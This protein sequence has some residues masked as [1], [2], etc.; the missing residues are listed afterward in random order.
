MTAAAPLVQTL[1]RINRQKSD[2]IS[3]LQ[4]CP[5]LIAVAQTQLK[6]AQDH[7]QAT[8]QKLTKARLDAEMKQL[9]MKERE[10]KIH[11]WRGKMNAAKENREYQALKDQIAADTQANVVLSDEILE[12]LESIDAIG[13]ELQQA[14][15]DAKAK[16]SECER[17]VGEVEQRRQ[18]LENELARVQTE[19]TEAELQLSGDFKRDYQRLVAT[20]SDDAMAELEGNCCGGCCQ[21]LTPMLIERLTTGQSIACPSCGRLVYKNQDR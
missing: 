7:I 8:R 13:V 3:Q 1:H 14:E 18:V 11:N 17:I 5:K 21:S 10:Q 9:Q 15:A 2:L 6:Q 4:R 16:Q 19:L 20:K 12:L